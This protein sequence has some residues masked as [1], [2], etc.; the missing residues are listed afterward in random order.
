M[1]L[2]RKVH[3]SRHTRNFPFGSTQWRSN[4]RVD[5]YKRRSYDWFGC[6]GRRAGHSCSFASIDQYWRSQEIAAGHN[7]IS[8]GR[9]RC[10]C[11]RRLCG[12][13]WHSR[14]MM[15]GLPGFRGTRNAIQKSNFVLHFGNASCHHTPYFHHWRHCL[16]SRPPS[17]CWSVES[18]QSVA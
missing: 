9:D 13:V 5:G 16:M 7:G 17:Y 10:C 2:L 4:W 11:Y 3:G 12:Q 18:I 14:R 1:L 8:F 15:G 6:L